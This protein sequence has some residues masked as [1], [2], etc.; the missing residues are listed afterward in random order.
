MTTITQISGSTALQQIVTKGNI[1]TFGFESSSGMQAGQKLDVLFNTTLQPLKNTW[2]VNGSLGLKQGELLVDPIY[3]SFAKPANAQF[4]FTWSPEFLDITDIRYQHADILDLDGYIALNLGKNFKIKEI[5]FRMAQTSL[6]VLYETYLKGWL[7]N[8]QNLELLTSGAVAAEF[9]WDT[10]NTMLSAQLYEVSLEN[11]QKSFGWQGIDGTIQWHSRDE[12]MPTELRWSGGYFGKV[13]L[14]KSVLKLDLSGEKAGLLAPF[15]Q[16][17]L[18]GALRV[19]KFSLRNMGKANMSWEMQ[20]SLK[21]IS[22]ESMTRTLGFPAMKGAIAGSLPLLRYQNNQLQAEGQVTLKVFDGNIIFKDLRLENLSSSAPVLKTNI[23]IQKIDLKMLTGVTNFG[24]IQGQ[25]SG[26]IKKLLLKNW[27]PVSFDAYFA[28]PAD[29]TLPRKIS[30]KAV[31]S[32][33][34]LG[35]G[36]VVNALSQGVLSLFEDFAYEKITWGCR[37]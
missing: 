37:L 22:M 8:S 23:D 36:G 2:K 28:T 30:Q 12:D 17:I 11:K 15:E 14:G 32:L 3:V 1:D 31:N 18:D 16:P 21:Q 34:N 13:N 29:N 10:Q 35:G 6:P 26:Y 24:E 20:P 7:Q 25:L 4:E 33:S 19:E 9:G 27:Q 5:F